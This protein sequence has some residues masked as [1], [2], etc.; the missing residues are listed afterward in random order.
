ME[1]LNKNE[2]NKNN[3]ISSEMGDFEIL[4]ESEFIDSSKD[5]LVCI[6]Q[7]ENNLLKY[8]DLYVNITG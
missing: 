3:Y 7:I 6:K 2:E 4:D 1:D 5:K 8:N